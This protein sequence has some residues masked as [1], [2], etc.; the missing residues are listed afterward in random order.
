[1]KTIEERLNQMKDD[2]SRLAHEM[3]KAGKHSGAQLAQNAVVAVDE[4]V[5]KLPVPL[6]AKWPPRWLPD[7][8]EWVEIE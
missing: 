4:L 2:L 7:Q 8:L 1:M 3:N 6:V 5:E